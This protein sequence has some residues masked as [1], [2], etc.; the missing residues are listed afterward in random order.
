MES[1]PVNANFRRGAGEVHELVQQRVTGHRMTVRRVVGQQEG[2]RTGPVFPWNPR[3][4]ALRTEDVLQVLARGGSAHVPKDLQLFARAVTHPSYTWSGCELLPPTPGQSLEE[5]YGR[6]ARSFA[7]E[8]G[9]PLDPTVPLED[10][11]AVGGCSYDLLEFL[12]DSVVNLCIVDHLR[13]RFPDKQEGFLTKMKIRLVCGSQLSAFSQHL[14]LVPFLRLGLTEELSGSR[15]NMKLQEDMFEAFIGALFL[16]AGKDVRVCAEVIEKVL[17]EVVNFSDLVQNDTNYKDQ[18]LRYYALHFQGQYPKYREIDAGN[19]AGT[20]LMGV[21][22]P[23]EGEIVATGE[24]RNK[25]KAEQIAS[26]NAL[27]YFGA[28]D[29]Y[30]VRN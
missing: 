29:H 13:R 10:L 8:Q 25:R 11:P 6:E 16:D 26:R 7:A 5:R 22:S 14:G 27:I 17:E 18:L 3:N 9:M 21:L 2:E 15:E 12:G 23:D 19:A 30:A 28:L 1:H 20:Y 4:R 24:H